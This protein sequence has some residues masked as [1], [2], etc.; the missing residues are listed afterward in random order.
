MT[1]KIQSE[2]VQILQRVQWPLCPS[3]QVKVPRTQVT[4]Q[5]CRQILPMPL[6][7]AGALHLLP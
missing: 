6:K 4:A 5:L 2:H 3:H 7:R 1:D